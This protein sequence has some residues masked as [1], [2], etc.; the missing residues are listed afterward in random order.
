MS[1]VEGYDTKGFGP[2]EETDPVIALLLGKE[3]EHKMYVSNHAAN[4]LE[5]LIKQSMQISEN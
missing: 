5:Q 2:V 4:A 1:A 3:K